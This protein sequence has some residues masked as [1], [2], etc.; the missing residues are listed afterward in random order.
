MSS[1]RTWILFVCGHIPSA[2]GQRM[3]K[4]KPRLSREQWMLLF[5]NSQELLGTDDGLCRFAASWHFCQQRGGRERQEENRRPLASVGSVANFWVEFEHI[6]CPPWDPVSWLMQM[7]GPN[8]YRL[9]HCLAPQYYT[10][11]VE[12]MNPEK[13]GCVSNH[14]L[15]MQSTFFHWHSMDSSLSD[16]ISLISLICCCLVTKSCLILLQSCGLEPT[17]LLCPWD[18]PG[19]FTAVGCHFLLQGIFLTHGSNPCP[20][21]CRWILYCWAS[22]E[23]HL[24][25]SPTG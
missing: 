6:A 8:A 14:D 16:F 3:L 2:P 19:K 10:D 17:R 5:A 22:R 4:N 25:N 1:M 9:F 7:R 15:S 18:F 24:M 21:H 13:A 20:L 23:A 12:N 11:S